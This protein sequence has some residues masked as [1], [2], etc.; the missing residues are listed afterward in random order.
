MQLTIDEF[1]SIG[2]FYKIDLDSIASRLR[3]QLSRPV[4][5]W[6]VDKFIREN[7]P[8][9]TK[10]GMVLLKSKAPP[11]IIDPGQ[12]LAERFPG[13]SSL[14]VKPR[15]TDY[16]FTFVQ[17]PTDRQVVFAAFAEAFQALKKR[18]DNED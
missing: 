13:Q 12:S 15:S 11:Q 3:K 4:G 1:L 5:A 17:T 18:D 8:K 9:L 16:L 10:R 14:V 2:D 7:K 6:S